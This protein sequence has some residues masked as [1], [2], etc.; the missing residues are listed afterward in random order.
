MVAGTSTPAPGAAATGPEP[1]AVQL[2]SA[3][4]TVLVL[5][6]GSAAFE[7]L[8]ATADRLRAAAD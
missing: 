6:P 8:R 2:G 7:R 3:D 5:E 1:P 4:G